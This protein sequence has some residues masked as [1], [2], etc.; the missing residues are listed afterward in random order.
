M[1]NKF[2]YI[3]N[4]SYYVIN[5]L[6]TE[7]FEIVQGKKN[8][9]IRAYQGKIGEKIQT[10]TKNNFR[11]VEENIVKMDEITKLPDWIVI[12]PGGEKYL[13]N[14]SNFRRK[15]EELE[16]RKGYYRSRKKSVWFLQIDENISFETLRGSL[17]NIKNGGYLVISNLND[18]YG[19]QKEEFEE[20]YKVV[21][22]FKRM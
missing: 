21:E 11:E 13:V 20:T 22:K 3:N 5:K 12:N 15:Y 16:D 19:I 7:K 1:L 18:I 4:I 2:K 14:D 8:V 10:I 6:I 9:I 17:M